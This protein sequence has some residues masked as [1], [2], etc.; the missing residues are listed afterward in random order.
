[1]LFAV[2]FEDNP[3]A[4]PSLRPRHMDAHLAYLT[5][6]RDSVRSAGPLLDAEGEVKGGMW[7]VEAAGP[8]E[9]DHLVKND[10]FWPTGLRKAYA[11]RQWR[12]VFRDGEP[13]L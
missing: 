3:A 11:I 9:V 6:N 8:G 2:I 13:Q 7:L 12:Q 5:E 4:D 10:P 1:M